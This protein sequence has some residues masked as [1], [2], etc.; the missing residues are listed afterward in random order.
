LL[1]RIPA[2]AADASRCWFAV[3]NSHKSGHNQLNGDLVQLGAELLIIALDGVSFSLEAGDRLGLV[4]G[5]GAGKTTLLKTLYG[6]YEPSSGTV[7]NNGRVDALFNINLGFRRE[8]TGR[9]N[10]IIR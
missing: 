7:T 3:L 5:N 2:A 6:I 1:H 4:G 9:R 8:A 10:I